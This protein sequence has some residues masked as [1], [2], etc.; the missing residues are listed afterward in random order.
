MN[1]SVRVEN[2]NGFRVKRDLVA[3]RFCSKGT[4]SKDENASFFYVQY[5]WALEM[6]SKQDLYLLCWQGQDA[7]QNGPFELLGWGAKFCVSLLFMTSKGESRQVQSSLVCVP[8]E[9]KVVLRADGGHPTKAKLVKI[10]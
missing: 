4:G 3:Q 1:D 10:K 8:A 7:D 5:L 2:H 9:V 6:A